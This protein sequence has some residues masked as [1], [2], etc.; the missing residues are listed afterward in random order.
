MGKNGGH[1]VTLWSRE[2]AKRCQRTRNNARRNWLHRKESRFGLRL[3]GRAQYVANVALYRTELHPRGAVRILEELSPSALITFS[4]SQ[5][6]P[7]RDDIAFLC[8]RLLQQRPTRVRG[9]PTGAAQPAR[10]SNWQHIAQ[11]RAG[12]RM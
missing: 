5:D 8:R 4:W 7:D 12:S 11:G 10:A 6:P 9:Y 3:Q 2:D 1:A